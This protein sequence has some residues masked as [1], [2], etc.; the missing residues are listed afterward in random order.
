MRNH[1]NSAKVAQQHT[2][3][4]NSRGVRLPG[5][6]TVTGVLNKPALVGWANRLGLDGIDVKKYVNELAEIGTCAHYMIECHINEQINSTSVKPNLE[7][8]T[9]KQIEAATICFDKYINWEKK[10]DIEYMAS[11]LVLTHDGL[12]YGGT[13]DVLAILNGK[14]TLLDI[15]T[16]KAIYNEHFL[17]VGGGYMPLLLK[18]NYAVEKARIIRCG[19]DAT[20]GAE[21]EDKLVPNLEEYQAMFRLCLKIY[22]VKKVLNFY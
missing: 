17:Q 9:G 13:V 1:K 4:K 2:V 16:C 12:M 6:T 19:R 22:G 10:Q 7:N 8:Y 11:E 21:A 5:C 15:K 3:Y 14:C 20:E 18:H